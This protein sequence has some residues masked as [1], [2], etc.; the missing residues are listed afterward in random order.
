MESARQKTTNKTKSCSVSIATIKTIDKD[1]QRMLLPLNLFHNIL[2]CPKYRIK[3]N[4]INPNSFLSIILG[5]FGLILSIFSFCYRVYKYYRINPKKYV[6]NVMYVTSYIDFVIFSIGTIINF[7]I[8]VLETVRNVSLVLKIQD[9]HR[10]L[11]GQNYF[12]CFTIWNWISIFSG[13][14]FYTYMLI[15][16]VLTFE[17]HIDG[18]LFGFTLLF[19]DVNIIYCIRLIKLINNKV[20]IWNRR[21]LKMH[22][23][24]P[25]DNED[26]CEK[27]F[28]AYMNILKCY[29][30]YKDSFQLM[31]RN[32][33]FHSSARYF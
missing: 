1:M 15:F 31:V 7:K 4:F 27:M 30:F 28:E 11:P 22:Q 33:L 13:V 3:N 26:Y 32:N 5:L 14:G 25:I 19:I 20:D 12:K 9:I 18:M 10:F 23:M 16:T 17:M 8:N 29:D 6:M 21:A 24:D 2:L